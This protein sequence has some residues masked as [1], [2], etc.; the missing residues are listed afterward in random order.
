MTWDRTVTLDC[1]CTNTFQWVISVH[2]RISIS[3][4]LFCIEF[5]IS[6]WTVAVPTHSSGLLAFTF[7]LA[8]VELYFALKFAISLSHVL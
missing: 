5:A 7:A 1:S 2:I 4:A 6:H 8:L 3:R